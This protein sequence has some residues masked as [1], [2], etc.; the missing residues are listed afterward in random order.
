MSDVGVGFGLLF[1][2]AVLFV[3]ALYLDGKRML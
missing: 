2:L 3:V 1:A